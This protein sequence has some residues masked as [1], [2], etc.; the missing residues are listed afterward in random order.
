ML[1]L[2]AGVPRLVV[3]R[4]G[5]PHLPENLQP[6]L[7]QATQGT[8]VRLPLVAVRL[9]V[10]LRPGAFVATVIGP[11]VDRRAQRVVARVAHFLETHLA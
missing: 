4:V 9:I 5:L 10:G 6:A 3:G 1:G 2:V 7:A 11:E 8:S